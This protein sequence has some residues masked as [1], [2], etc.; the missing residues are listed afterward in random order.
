VPQTIRG[1]DPFCLW[2]RL[3]PS[4]EHIDR[5]RASVILKGME[6]RRLTYRRSGRLAA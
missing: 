4:Q 3:L 1:P 2:A 5:E 6:G